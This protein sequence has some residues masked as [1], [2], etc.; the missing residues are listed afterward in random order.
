MMIYY[1]RRKLLFLG[2]TCTALYIFYNLS[3]VN[4]DRILF[5]KKVYSVE[6]F[7]AILTARL[8]VNKKT[9]QRLVKV[10]DCAAIFNG[11][12][13]E[14]EKAKELTEKGNYTR[15]FIKDKEYVLLTRNCISFKSKR[16]YD[17]FLVSEE[18]VNFP[19]A[20]SILLYKDVEQVERLLRAIY[21]PQNYYCL[22]VDA[23]CTHEVHDAIQGIANCFDNV[24][25]V[26]RKEYVVYAGFTRLQ[27]DLNCM[28][29]LLKLSGDWKYFINL[30]SQ[31]FP[32]KTNKEIVKILEIYNG[33]N[34]IPGRTGSDSLQFRYS[35]R[36]LYRHVQNKTKPNIIK[37][38]QEKETPP[39]NITVVK[40]SAYG[41]FSRDFVH[42][43]L[44][45]KIARAVLDYF[46]DVY[47]PDE[48]Y[49]ATLN[50][51]HH[52]GA[53]GSYY[54]GISFF[55]ISVIQKCIIS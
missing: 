37:S 52:I 6:T 24:F 13:A 4:E 19:I 10:V 7:R 31:E 26:S 27:A 8:T 50:Y 35:H 46:R 54:K 2:I 12:N 28:E 20:F 25:V 48:Y 14:I 55:R 44:N 5:M 9:P 23:D 15:E 21:A 18:E 47:S 22:H 1:L 41:V 36:Y 38:D 43:A 16:G 53:P 17:D 45:N 49:W 40:G 29:D 11:D 33:A 42:F 51:N 39:Y 30:P 34:D 32:L 3:I